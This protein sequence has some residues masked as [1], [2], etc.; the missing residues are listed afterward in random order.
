MK[1]ST[2]VKVQV[3]DRM[4]ENGINPNEE[5]EKAF[6]AISNPEF[7]IAF[8]GRSQVGKSHAINK[9]YLGGSSLLPEGNGLSTSA[10][11][12]KVEKGDRTS[13]IYTNREKGSTIIV[14]DPLPA[15]IAMFTANEN[16]KQRRELHEVFTDVTLEYPSELLENVTVF[17]TPGINDVDPILLRE[18]TYRLIPEMDAIVM[19]VLARELSKDELHF[20][21]RRVFAVGIYNFML[22][23][24]CRKSDQMGSEGYERV[25]NV[26]RNQLAG[27]GM[28]DIPVVLYQE[29]DNG[30][31]IE[32]EG[33]SL[34][35]RIIEF[36]RNATE[37]NRLGRLKYEITKQLHET[38]MKLSVEN[39]L[40]GKNEVE[41]RQ[42]KIERIQKLEELR[43][44]MEGIHTEFCG[45]LTDLREACVKNF[46]N[47]LNI[48]FS[49]F[50]QEL[51]D[52]VGFSEA[53][54][55]LDGSE[56]ILMPKI[57]DVAVD[58]ISKFYEN[59]EESIKTL[60]GK[61]SDHSQRYYDVDLGKVDG[62]FFQNISDMIVVGLDYLLT[63]I[64]CPGPFWP[65]LG[66]RWVLGKIPIIRNVMLENIAK[67]TM[68]R[69]VRGSLEE[70]KNAL[71]HDFEEQ[72]EK[73]QSSLLEKI[74]TMLEEEIE[75]EKECLVK[76]EGKE[77]AMDNQ[78]NADC[79]N[80]K[81]NL[82]K[83]LLEQ[84][85]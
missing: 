55:L 78:S 63:G 77:Q 45:K 69:K 85:D 25:T 71:V 15:T 52:A 82:I 38:L 80:Q 1:E 32:D 29:D 24:S 34:S 39:A 50:I 42:Q 70:Q 40:Y 62:G 17:D 64:L 31:V 16:E 75:C 22:L 7:K 3:V 28:P 59:V 6:S 18:T 19:V 56:K 13:F 57:E 5:V 48:L 67:E 84:L 68:T 46:K 12:V 30:N 33:V 10:L 37:Q 81:I 35:H 47:D 53:Q 79:I 14:N 44:F 41:L 36:A 51:K 21:Q 76:L 8:V 54:E 49:Q 66:L 61:V 43:S 26:I 23:V 2:K 27:I 74:Q 83:D 60:K 20:L 4:K 58:N 72:M 73:V 65:I 9:L 11:T